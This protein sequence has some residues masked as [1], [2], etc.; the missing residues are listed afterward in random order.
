MKYLL[1]WIW[2]KIWKN[3][4]IAVFSAQNNLTRPESQ[5]HKEILLCFGGRNITFR[6]EIF[7][8]AMQSKFILFV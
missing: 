5:S 8:L 2:R 6:I 1:D 4:L 3:F 7:K